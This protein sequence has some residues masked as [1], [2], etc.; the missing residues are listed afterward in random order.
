[1]RKYTFV[2][3]ALVLSTSAARAQ[4]TR[5]QALF[6]GEIDATLHSA[7]RIEGED[8]FSVAR[9][10]LG[11]RADFTRSFYAVAQAEWAQE[12]PAL[13]DAYVS[14]RPAPSWEV[15]FGARKTPLFSAARDEPVWMLPVP[16]RPMIVRALWP[17]RDVG[18]EVHRLPTRSMPLEA[19]LRVGNGSGSV[20]GN[21]NSDFALDARLDVA[22]GRANGDVS[23]APFF[24]L[25]LGSGVHVE[26]AEDRLG[27]RAT[28]ADGFL[29]YR[30]PTVFGPRYV[31]E[32]HASLYLGPV[33]IQGELGTARESRA[34]DTDG[35]PDTP[36]VPLDSI[37]STGGFVEAA[38]MLTGQRRSPGVWPTV[39]PGRSW[40]F[41]AL[42][43]AGRFERISLGRGA[44]D[45]EP[46]GATSASFALRW[47]ATRYGALSAAGYVTA[48]DVAPIEEPGTTRSFLGIVRA[49]FHVPV[50]KR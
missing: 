42:E 9:L 21:D 4:D 10:R 23:G 12:K 43:L 5:V 25:R 20:L 40:G 33:R 50:K 18:L 32:A 45:I 26:N 28:S 36:R 29:F 35:N 7:E 14:L 47:W 38:W 27:V 19:W 1:M 34:K 3:A 13:L 2:A 15:S 16:E 48:Y 11:A 22:L 39:S 30:S 41:G 31:A 17:S 44:R 49:T 6:V 46:G 37:R 8:G 24:G